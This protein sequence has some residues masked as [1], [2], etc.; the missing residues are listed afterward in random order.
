[1]EAWRHSTIDVTPAGSYEL[2]PAVQGV[3][4]ARASLEN[5]SVSLLD[6]EAWYDLGWAVNYEES[7]VKV[8]HKTALAFAA[9]FQ[10]ITVIANDLAKLPLDL[11]RRNGDK[12]EIAAD[13]PA[14]R[15][16]RRNPNREQTWFAFWRD[17]FAQRLLWGQS[18]TY[19]DRDLD[20]NPIELIPLLSDRTGFVRRDGMLWVVTEVDDKLEPIDPNDCLIL[21]GISIDNCNAI[22]VI[23]TARTVV[24][25]G[26]AMQGF[27]SKFFENGA[28]ARGIL[29]YPG[30][31]SEKAQGNVQKSFDAQYKGLSNAHKTMILEEGMKFNR[32]TIAPNEGQ[33]IEGRQEQIREIARIFN[34]PP[35]KLG[36]NSRVSYNSLEQENKSY[37][38]ST[39]DSHLIGAAAEC[40]AK[41]LSETEKEANSHYFEHNREA[42]LRTDL[43]TRMKAYLDQLET[44]SITPN[45]IAAME[46]LPDAGPQ[47]DRRF[48]RGNLMP[49]DPVEQKKPDA[50]L[51]P[52]PNDQ[53]PADPNDPAEPTEANA[54][55]RALAVETVRRIAKRFLAKA[56]RISNSNS[57]TKVSQLAV[58]AWEDRLGAIDEITRVG[59]VLG[60]QWQEWM[61][62]RDAKLR[63]SFSVPKTGDELAELIKETEKCLSN[64]ESE[65]KA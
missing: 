62:E 60:E 9:V 23:K 45:M 7:G 59:D 13:H 25:L 36:D 57:A 2:P 8:T 34:L 63:E 22:D 37:L 19:I 28:N 38:D 3:P 56:K 5:P 64:E 4:M 52:Q 20:G 33:F 21:N 50:A 40:D 53:P 6:P 31:L 15:L 26:L 47:G 58:M 39:L 61:I 42:L 11:Y 24:S 49:L 55:A 29:E 65:P 10:A 48:I 14:Y 32:M 1:M 35:H 51:P 43:A 44:G 17:R 54:P 41:L 30:K 46:N 12:R 16:V 27:G 18:F